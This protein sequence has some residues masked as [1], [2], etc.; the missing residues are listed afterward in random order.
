MY[1]DILDPVRRKLVALTSLFVSM[2]TKHLPMNG[3]Q[4]RPF[5]GW[6]LAAMDMN[7]LVRAISVQQTAL[8]FIL[9]CFDGFDAVRPWTKGYPTSSD[10]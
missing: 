4:Y 1:F 7:R 3:Q 2:A 9:F 8:L 5:I 6:R 10:A